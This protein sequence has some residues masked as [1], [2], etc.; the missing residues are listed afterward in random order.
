M[1]VAICLTPC[2]S[3]PMLPVVSTANARVTPP[4]SPISLENLSFPIAFFKSLIT[5]EAEGD[6]VC[7]LPLLGVREPVHGTNVV[8]QRR[9]L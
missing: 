3:S 7:R 6:D 9:S 2:I 5:D 1:S 8:S 4:S